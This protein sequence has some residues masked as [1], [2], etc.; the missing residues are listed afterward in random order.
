MSEKSNENSETYLPGTMI[1]FP[2]GG[3][4][5][6]LEEGIYDRSHQLPIPDSAFRPS[7][8]MRKLPVRNKR[9]LKKH[10]PWWTFNK[11]P[12]A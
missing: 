1:H 9:R 5:V 3:Y 11:S 7:M 4:V 6:W 10:Q 8:L 12:V 2:D